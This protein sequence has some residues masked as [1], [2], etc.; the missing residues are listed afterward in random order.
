MGQSLM[1]LKMQLNSFKRRVKRGQEDWLEFDQ[2]ID[3]VNVIADQTRKICQSL[4]PT[5]LENLG[6][7]G[8]LRELLTEFQK[9][10]GLEVAEEFADLSGLFAKEA[11][12]T[13]YRL[14]QECLTNA[15]RHGKATRVTVGSKKGDGTVCYSCADN[16]AGFDLAAVR[17]RRI[18]GMGLAAIEE[19]VRLLQG[20]F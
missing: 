8:A 4:R 19:R 15:V 13:V 3:F 18:P 6:L 9:H 2:A 20:Y 1:A 10:H 5:A 16:G 11:Q 14:F 17:S 7:N 12:I